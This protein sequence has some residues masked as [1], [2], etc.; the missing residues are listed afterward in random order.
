MTEDHRAAVRGVA[1]VLI[2][3]KDLPEEIRSLKD[4]ITSNLLWVVTE[5]KPGPK[6]KIHGVRWRTPAAH[7]L[8]EMR[9]TKTLRHEHVIERRWM[10]DFLHD[11]PEAISVAL[12]NYPACIVT[13]DEHIALGRSTEWGWARYLEAQLEVIDGE[14]GRPLDLMKSDQQ[15]KHLFESM[16]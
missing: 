12:W 1:D 8:A 2:A 15:L 5:H 4:R 9:D 11:H 7:L 6:Q 13:V 14:T 16:K 10:I 3:L